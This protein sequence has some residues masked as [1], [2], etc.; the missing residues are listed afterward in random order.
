MTEATTQELHEGIRQREQL[1]D[2]ASRLLAAGSGEFSP[3]YQEFVLLRK[4]LV[5]ISRTRDLDHC[6]L[7]VRKKTKELRLW[8][9]RTDRSLGSMDPV[10]AIIAY[11]VE[12]AQKYKHA[13]HHEA[14]VLSEL[15]IALERGDWVPG[16]QPQ[17]FYCQD[18]DKIFDDRE[19]LFQHCAYTAC[20]FRE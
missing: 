3:E 7:M 12:Q 19:D 5:E 6:V 20:S 2:E 14:K 9:R 18:C 17:R 1:L 8:L 13:P 10:D 15:L 11:V 4:E 16:D